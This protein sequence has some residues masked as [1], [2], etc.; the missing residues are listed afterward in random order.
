M[1]DADPG[2]AEDPQVIVG[3][4]FDDPALPRPGVPDGLQTRLGGPP[5][6]MQLLRDAVIVSKDENGRTHVKETTDPKPGSAALSGGMWAGLVRSADRRGPSVGRRGPAHRRRCGRRPPAEGDRHR[7]ARRVGGVV[8]GGRA[9]PG[10][11]TVAHLLV[12]A[13]STP[14]RFVAE[15]ERFHRLGA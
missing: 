8:Q 13:G 3:L 7:A 6:E 15:A 9:S 12:E 5:D 1:S 14:A 10:K 4:S 11:V 2:P